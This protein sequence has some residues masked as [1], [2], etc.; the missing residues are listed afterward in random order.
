MTESLLLLADREAYPSRAK[1]QN[2]FE[3][4]HIRPARADEPTKKMT[5]DDRTVL[6]DMDEILSLQVEEPLR[7]RQVAGPEEGRSFRV[8]PLQEAIIGREE[9]APICLD[10]KAVSRQHAKI[11]Y[12]KRFP[13]VVDL[14]SANGIF[15][16]GNRV[17]KADLRDGDTL[18]VGPCSFEIDFGTDASA[19]AS[20]QPV[21]PNELK[22]IERALESSQ[23]KLPK[24]FRHR[25][26]FSG[27]LADIGLMSLLQTLG[28]N[29]SHGS[30]LIRDASREGTVYLDAGELV[31]ATLGKI[32][33]PKALYRLVGIQEGHFNFYTPGRKPELKSFDGG[34]ERHLLEAARQLDELSTYQDQLPEDTARLGFKPKVMVNLSR[35]PSP[36]LDVIAVIGHVQIMAEV[37]DSCELPDLDVCRILLMLIQRNIL[38]ATKG[39]EHVTEVTPEDARIVRDMMKR[40]E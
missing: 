20:Y 15:V 35:V 6:V 22:R 34:L 9:N 23:R 30:L 12:K 40:P 10:E 25:S 36:V 31:H 11:D 7:L 27:E 28:A 19:S 3:V 17:D 39:S 29:R 1:S 38:V 33:G 26:A 21:S 14:G 4:A 32:S 18:Q 24:L 37:V 16:N 8:L 13:M 2:K 5:E